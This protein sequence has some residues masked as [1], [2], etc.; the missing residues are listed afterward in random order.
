MS[1]ES[2]HSDSLGNL[3]EYVTFPPISDLAHVSMIP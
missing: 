2:N 1:H 3:A